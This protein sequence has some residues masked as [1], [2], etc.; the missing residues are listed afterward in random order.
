MR[1][2][3][4]LIFLLSGVTISAKAQRPDT[5]TH[6]SKTDSL[7]RKLDTTNS[8]RFVPQ[9]RKEKEY[10]PDSTHSPHKAVM[11]S[12]IVPGWG[13]WY[14]KTGWWWKIPA[15]YGGL[16]A[17]GYNIISNQNSYRDFLAVAEFQRT[18]LKADAPSLKGD[19]RQPLYATYGGY[20]TT[21]I[22]DAKEGYRRNRDLSILGFLAVWGVNIIDAYIDAKFIHSFSMDNNFGTKVSFGTIQQQPVYASNFNTTFTP[23]LKITVTLK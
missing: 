4:I 15:I 16:G 13:Q 22:I 8:R 7:Y 20:S 17:L 6:R 11:R 14:N 9:V 1:R 10:H 5:V 18:G 23:A 2:Y 12:L 21:A 19:P 3:F